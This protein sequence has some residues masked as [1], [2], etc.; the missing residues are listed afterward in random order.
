MSS[1]TIARQRH[2][3]LPGMG[4]SNR[5]NQT[6]YNFGAGSATTGYRFDQQGIA[7]RLTVMGEVFGLSGSGTWTFDVTVYKDG[8]T[9]S[10][11][12]FALSFSGSAATYF[13]DT[14]TTVLSASA[15]FGTGNDWIIKAVSGLGGY[16]LVSVAWSVVLEGDFYG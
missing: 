1:S 9:A 6:S 2:W 13:R 7:T 15:D 4:Q 3:V 8:I 14:T 11:D 16:T 12:V 5:N 10:D